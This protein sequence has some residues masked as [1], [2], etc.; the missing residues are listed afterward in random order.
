MPIYTYLCK[1][2]GKITTSIRS[3]KEEE[4]NPTNEEQACE[5]P[6]PEWEKKIYAPVNRYRFADY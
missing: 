4:R 6:E 5:C 2:C 1:S 3:I